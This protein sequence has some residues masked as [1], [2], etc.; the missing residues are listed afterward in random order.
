[1]IRRFNTSRPFWMTTAALIAL[2]SAAKAEPFDASAPVEKP[3]A[4]YKFD[5]ITPFLSFSDAYGDRATGAHGTFG[6]IPAKTAS[7]SHIHSAAY[8]GVVIKGVMTDG[9]NGEKN[10]PRLPP[11]SYWYV[12]AN[13]VHITACV[14]AEPCL[15]YTH[16]DDKF[17]FAPAEPKP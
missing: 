13:A 10:P 14:S 15:F 5:T 4:D 16:S 17:D 8:H 3:A 2:A 11:G 9:F 1:M 6:V 7:P 12:P